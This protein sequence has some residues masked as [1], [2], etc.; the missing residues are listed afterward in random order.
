MIRARKSGA[1]LAQ[2]G[3]TLVELMITLA[4]IALLATMVYPVREL[5]VKRERERE[6]RSALREI[7]VALDA[8]HKATEEGRVQKPADASGYPESLEALESGIQDASSPDNN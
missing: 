8:Y 4:I 3:F 7:R 2:G 1:P 6:L 5:S